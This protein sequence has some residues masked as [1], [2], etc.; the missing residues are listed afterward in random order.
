M[1][2]VTSPGA[3]YNRRMASQ[4]SRETIIKR[5][6]VEAGQASAALAGVL[7]AAGGWS[8]LA[9]LIFVSGRLPT[10]PNRWLFYVLVQIALTGS[11]VPFVR[12]L[13]RRFSHE[14][15]LFIPAGVMIRQAIWFGLWGTVCLWLRIPR[16]LSVPTAIVI[17]IAMI[18]IELLL[19][20]RERMQWRP[21]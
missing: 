9:W 11:A 18:V 6:Q 2:V 10:V 3:L 16:L 19:R 12:L 13:H 14:G 7:L 5:R 17:A 8:G 21:G 20:L 15:A 4:D 1:R